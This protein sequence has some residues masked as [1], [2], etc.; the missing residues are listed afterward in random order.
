MKSRL[1]MSKRWFSLN[2]RIWLVTI[3]ES[4][5]GYTLRIARVCVLL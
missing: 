4:I 3:T 2:A 1:L 5:G